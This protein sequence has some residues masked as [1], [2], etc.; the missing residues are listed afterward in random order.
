MGLTGLVRDAK[1]QL[2]QDGLRARDTNVGFVPLLHLDGRHRL[3]H[4]WE[5]SW[6]FDGLAAPQGRALDLGL[7]VLRDV[8]DGWQAGYGYRTLEGGVDNDRVFNF[9]WIHYGFLALT[10]RY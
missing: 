3:G 5:L 1:V 8:G 9:S 4:S 7:K 6:D 10:Y 2:E